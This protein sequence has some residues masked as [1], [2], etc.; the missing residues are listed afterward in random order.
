MQG[1]M[2]ACV[3]IYCLYILQSWICQIQHNSSQLITVGCAIDS[4]VLQDI[5]SPKRETCHQIMKM[6]HAWKKTKEKRTCIRK[7][8]KESISRKLVGHLGA[9][10]CQR[11]VFCVYHGF[12]FYLCIF[13]VFIYYSLC[14]FY[15]CLFSVFINYFLCLFIIIIICLCLF[16][17]LIYYYSNLSMS[18]FCVYLLFLCVYFIHVYFLCSFIIFCVYLLFYFIYVYCL[19]LSFCVYHTLSTKK[20]F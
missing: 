15:L 18:I 5:A 6:R 1:T 7:V 3:F 13:S 11:A 9:K 10:L 12:L 4:H 8:R 17:V 14:L 16:S 19:C 20:K 2:H